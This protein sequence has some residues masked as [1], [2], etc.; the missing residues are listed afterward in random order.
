M[1]CCLS[2]SVCLC[3]IVTVMVSILVKCAVYFCHCLRATLKSLSISFH[4]ELRNKLCVCCRGGPGH[5][6]EKPSSAIYLQCSPRTFCAGCHLPSGI[7]VCRHWY[8]KPVCLPWGTTSSLDLLCDHPS[9]IPAG[10]SHLTWIYSSRHPI[11]RHR[12]SLMSSTIQVTLPC[13]QP[14][15]CQLSHLGTHLYCCDSSFP[16]SAP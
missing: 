10:L 7:C 16:G 9:S 11:S 14:F 2:L 4:W 1:S 5:T 15:L 13:S 3:Y 8:S 12:P 6:Y